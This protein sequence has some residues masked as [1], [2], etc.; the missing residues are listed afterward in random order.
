MN[1]P[2]RGYIDV[3]S[4]HEWDYNTD[5]HLAYVRTYSILSRADHVTKYL[6]Q[7]LTIPILHA[8]SWSSH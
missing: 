6:V 5:L 8:G 3:P 4:L 1:E 2:H 7:S